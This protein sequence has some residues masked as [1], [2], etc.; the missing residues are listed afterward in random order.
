M[1]SGDQLRYLYDNQRV[2]ASQDGGK[3][4]VEPAQ[5]LDEEA[6][7]DGSAWTQCVHAGPA[8]HREHDNLEQIE[9][10]KCLC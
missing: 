3:R 6:V 4:V 10:Q 8:R 7:P 2:L 5:A 1:E 9:E